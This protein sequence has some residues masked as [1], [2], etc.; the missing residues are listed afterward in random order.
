MDV[1]TPS[2]SP[3]II[4]TVIMI[5]IFIGIAIFVFYC[6]SNQVL[7][8]A[9]YH[10]PEGPE[11]FYPTPLAGVKPTPEQAALRERLLLEALDDVRLSIALKT[12]TNPPG[13]IVI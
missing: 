12:P 5:L 4:T 6:N 13:P 7:L 9:E 3:Y 2:K 11:W 1:S 8:F 10:P